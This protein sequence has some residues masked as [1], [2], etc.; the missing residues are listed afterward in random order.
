MTNSKF[1]IKSEIRNP[2]GK[3]WRPMSSFGHLSF[4]ILST[5]VHP[6][7]C[8]LLDRVQLPQCRSGKLGHPRQHCY[9]GRVIR[10]SSLSSGMNENTKKQAPNTKESPNLK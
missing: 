7:Q 4:V 3:L 6:P 8:C 10:I 1:R 5:F 2:N 9:G